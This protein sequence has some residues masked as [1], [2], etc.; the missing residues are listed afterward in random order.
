MSI[1]THS[2]SSPPFLFSS[3]LNLRAVLTQLKMASADS[4]QDALGPVLVITWF[5]FILLDLSAA[6]DRVNHFLLLETFFFLSFSS[7]TS[8][9]IDGSFSALHGWL[10]LC[11]LIFN[12]GSPRTQTCKTIWKNSFTYSFIF[13]FLLKNNFQKNRVFPTL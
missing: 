12:C 11:S 7:F 5:L 2:T 13:L 6:F 8:C 3:I 4:S 10:F 1:F 9:L